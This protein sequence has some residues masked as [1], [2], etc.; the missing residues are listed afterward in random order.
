VAT[1]ATGVGSRVND[2]EIVRCLDQGG[3]ANVYEA[4][5]TRS[6]RRIAIKVLRPEMVNDPLIVRRFFNEAR[7][8]RAIVHPG[9]VDIF[10]FGYMPDGLPFLMMELLA[11]ET[12]ARRIAR[13]GALD[14][15]TAVGIALET[16]SA[17][18]AAH[19]RGIVHRD[20]KPGNLLL[21]PHRTR[22]G[23][24]RT[25]VSER[26]TLIDF[27]IAKLLGAADDIA[28][29]NVATMVHPIDP[30]STLVG[31]HLGTPTYMAPEQWRCSPAWVGHRADIYSLGIVLYEMICGTPPFAGGYDDLMLLQLTA[32]PPLPSLRRPDLP[33]QLERVILRALAKNPADRFT[34]M[35]AFAAVLR[36]FAR[37][38]GRSAQAPSLRR[39][40]S[41]WWEWA[42]RAGGETSAP[43]V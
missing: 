33:A 5:H 38:G 2:H 21:G 39:R 25:H 14:V 22:A 19:A 29:R 23:G 34:S 13:M 11:G 43:R 26:V 17:L 3:M 9:V 12:L 36:P 10:D 20:V 35:A 8:A 6:G 7:A 31:T 28:G 15:H 42:V 30:V 16:A 4:V 18:C 32:A 37:Q 24:E 27:G 40:A 41:R 1:V